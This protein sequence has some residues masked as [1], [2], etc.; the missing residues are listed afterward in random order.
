MSQLER[1]TAVS[2]IYEKYNTGLIRYLEKRLHSREDVEDVAQEVWVRLIKHTGLDGL[3]PS[4]PLLCTIASNLIKDLLR[5]QSA[6]ANYRHV[7]LS[8]IDVKSKTASP[9][10][11]VISNEGIKKFKHIFRSLNKVHRQVFTLHRLEGYT[12]EEISI[13][14]GISKS[15]VYKHL[16]HAMLDLMGKFEKEL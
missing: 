11:I 7:S 2:A 4:L 10:E 3:E 16:N 13:K 6:K 15:T 5:K 1:A 14:M 12:Y 8:D 9:E